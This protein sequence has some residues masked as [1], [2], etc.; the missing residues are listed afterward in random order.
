MTF[1]IGTS[2]PHRPSPGIKEEVCREVLSAQCIL[3]WRII[4]YAE[5]GGSS[6]GILG[7]LGRVDLD[8]DAASSER[9]GVA[10]VQLLPVVPEL[11]DHLCD[12]MSDPASTNKTL[13]KT[14]SVVQEEQR[15]YAR[16]TV[17]FVRQNQWNYHSPFGDH[18]CPGTQVAG[19]LAG[20]DPAMSPPRMI[21]T[22]G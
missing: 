7:L 16:D 15:I 13:N 9:V 19:A 6:S 20:Q 8:A 3:V 11:V 21:W 12:S 4:T 17:E 5:E 1:E 14:Y 18:L 10:G 2:V 22:E